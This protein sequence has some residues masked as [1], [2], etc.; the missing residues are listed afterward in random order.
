MIDPDN[1]FFGCNANDAFGTAASPFECASD[2][3]SAFASHS[4]TDDCWGT[5]SSWSSDDSWSSS[6]DWSSSGFD[7]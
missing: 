4:A 6:S 1:D 3:S 2:S 5:A 7:W